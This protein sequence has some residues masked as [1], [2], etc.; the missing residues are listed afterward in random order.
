[1]A[2]NITRKVI[3]PLSKSLT[4]GTETIEGGT[5]AEEGLEPQLS[6]KSKCTKALGFKYVWETSAKSGYISKRTEKKC[7]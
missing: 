1:M 7:R 4:R 3:I 2:F 6:W 5:E